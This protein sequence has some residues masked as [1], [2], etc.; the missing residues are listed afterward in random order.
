MTDWSL[1]LVL[2]ESSPNWVAA[3]TCVSL[4][5]VAVVEWPVTWETMLPA[6]LAESGAMVLFQRQG[7]AEAVAEVAA[8]CAREEENRASAATRRAE[9]LACESQVESEGQRTNSLA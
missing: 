3:P 7:T 6:W 2:V 9:R 1:G 8:F 4:L 5:R